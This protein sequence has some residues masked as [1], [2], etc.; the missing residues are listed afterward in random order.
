MLLCFDYDGVIVDSFDSLLSVC[1]EAQVASAHG[2]AKPRELRA[3][4]KLTLPLA[5]QRS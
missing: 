3:S 1:V 5:R 2:R 4:G